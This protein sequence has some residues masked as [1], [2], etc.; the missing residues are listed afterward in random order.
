MVRVLAKN[1][2]NNYLATSFLK[3]A[4]VKR[5]ECQPEIKFKEKEQN[6][7]NVATIE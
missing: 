1:I 6:V 2:L 3:P 5:T 7:E 4:R